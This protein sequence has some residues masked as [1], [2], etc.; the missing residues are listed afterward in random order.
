M[1][2]RQ[3]LLLVTFIICQLIGT[4]VPQFANV[5]TNPW[6]FFALLLLIPGIGLM[7][8]IPETWTVTLT[9]A[10]VA[11]NGMVWYLVAKALA[12]RN[13]DSYWPPTS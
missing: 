8:V 1:N 10:V 3:T 2:R 7:F 6:P 11:V 12:T 13:P 5:H 4:V 9:L